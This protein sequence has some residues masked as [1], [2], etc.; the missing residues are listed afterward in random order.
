MEGSDQILS[1]TNVWAIG[2]V[3]YEL[4]TL[5]RLARVAFNRPG[6]NGHGC[7]EIITNKNPEYSQELLDLIRHCLKVDTCDRVDLAT[8]LFT[9]RRWIRATNRELAR[10]RTDPNVPCEGERL[11]YKDNEINEMSPGNY[12]PS[13]LH[14]QLQAESG[15]WNPDV[16]VLRYPHFPPLE[17][18]DDGMDQ[19]DEDAQNARE[20]ERQIREMDEDAAERAMD[21]ASM[22]PRRFQFHVTTQEDI[23]G[24]EMDVDDEPTV[25][26]APKTERPAHDRRFAAPGR[27][28]I[29]QFGRM[30]MG[31]GGY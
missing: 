14:Q 3:M 2:A 4:T 6:P 5:H 28:N 16:S 1:H 24:V 23:D 27:G 10:Q 18:S 26:Q 9:T 20:A 21:E 13:R 7:P 12:I 31:G 8:L 22:Y 29:N 30:Q 15:F 19:Q 25:G 11:Y 17:L